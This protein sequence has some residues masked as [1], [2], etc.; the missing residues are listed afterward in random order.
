MDA[1]VE[2]GAEPATLVEAEGADD[3]RTVDRDGS[4]P[5][6]IMDEEE[7]EHD[8]AAGGIESCGHGHHG[9]E[10]C[11]A[12]AEA[13]SAA[14]QELGYG[15]LPLVLAAPEYEPECS[16]TEEAFKPRA[17]RIKFSLP[18]LAARS[19]YGRSFAPGRSCASAMLLG[20]PSNPSV[21]NSFTEPGR[22]RRPPRHLETR[23]LLGFL[24]RL[25]S[26]LWASVPWLPD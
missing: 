8:G 16:G 10:G 4:D 25:A 14:D 15:D 17:K 12:A 24:P 7:E 21:A 13:A 6:E 20:L 19:V 22:K 1:D 18:E 23:V 9:G 5:I 11:E 3:G 2:P 26:E